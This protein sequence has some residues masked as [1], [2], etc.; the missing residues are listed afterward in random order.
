MNRENRPPEWARLL[1]RSCRRRRHAVFQVY[2]LLLSMLLLA[3]MRDALGLP[4]A[5][6]VLIGF[7]TV[8]ML[9]AIG[10]F[11]RCRTWKR[12]GR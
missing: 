6:P 10:E 7:W 8:A 2:A 3:L 5:V 4:I 9:A 1:L 12:A 11:D